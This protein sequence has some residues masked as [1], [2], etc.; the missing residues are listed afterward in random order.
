M[1]R[2]W[3][4]GNFKKTNRPWGSF[5]KLIGRIVIPGNKLF[6]GLFKENDDGRLSISVHAISNG[7][8]CTR[9]GLYWVNDNREIQQALDKI[10][11][12]IMVG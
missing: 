6:I 3:V 7:S 11:E 5:R 8:M 2:Y 1:M 12:T 9:L 4:V 10:Y